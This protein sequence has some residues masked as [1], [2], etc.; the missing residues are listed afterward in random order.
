MPLPKD[1]KNEKPAPTP[2][3]Q[4]D[5]MQKDVCNNTEVKVAEPSTGKQSK[6]AWCQ[7]KEVFCVIPEVI[8]S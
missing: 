1:I 7:E 4:K 8:D 6:E 3:V 5:G 2:T